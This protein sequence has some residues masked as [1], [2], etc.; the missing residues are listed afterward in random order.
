ML[1][2]SPAAPPRA[3]VRS[4]KEEAFRDLL[5]DSGDS[6]VD[7]GGG[8]GGGEANSHP[9]AKLTPAEHTLGTEAAAAAAAYSAAAA[10]APTTPTAESA[11]GNGGSLSTAA[12][13]P[14]RSSAGNGECVIG[15]LPP[16][17]LLQCAEYLG[18]TRSLCRVREVCHGW[19]VT[20]DDREAGQRLW[21]PLFY[22]LRASGS[23]HR[24]TDAT[25]QQHRQLKVYD[26]GT[27]TASAAAAA[28]PPNHRSGVG[29]AAIGRGPA[30]GV[31]GSRSGSTSSPLQQGPATPSGGYSSSSAGKSPG[32]PAQ[33]SA[34]VV[35]G[36]IQREGYSGRDCEMCAS[37]LVLVQSGD[38]PAAPA[39]ATPRLAYTR[40]NLSGGGSGPSPSKVPPFSSSSQRQRQQQQQ[41]QQHQHQQQGMP[42]SGSGS[43]P[44]PLVGGTANKNE[45]ESAGA[46]AAR[47]R[48][49]GGGGGSGGGGSVRGCGEEEQ[50]E[51]GESAR[52]IDWHFLVKRLAEEKRISGG[53]GSLHHG[54]VWL[55]RALQVSGTWRVRACTAGSSAP[56]GCSVWFFSAGGRSGG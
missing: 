45:S 51:L 18:D 12:P 49:A 32:P 21:R 54:W 15:T 55:Q 23:I 25:G 44:S 6:D 20:L 37:S 48:G 43:G 4:L 38:S 56:K 11:V 9:R 42:R 7:G 3:L 13:G 16:D 26:L 36:L 35:C 10:A 52:S 17:L 53:W 33:P 27:T 39:P 47:G 34:C 14:Y 46:G 50:E 8:G 31:S 40:V 29:S 5:E 41:Q 19:V 24:A 2:R 28:T 22:R 30:T 1:S